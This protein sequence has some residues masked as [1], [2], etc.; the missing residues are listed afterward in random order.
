[1]N[2]IKAVR[3][4]ALAGLVPLLGASTAVAQ[5][6]TITGTITDQESG[7]PLSSAQVVVVGT[8]IGTITNVEGAYTLRGVPAGT[9]S[10]RALSIGYS[11]QTRQVT[12]E[13]G[14]IATADFALRATAISM[15][16]MVVTATG[17]QRRIEVGNSIA[18][19]DASRITQQRAVSNF[20]DLM[21]SRTA[22]VQ[23]IPGT[24]TGAG[25]RFRIRGTS[26]LSLAN[27]PIF[28]IDGVRVE[29]TTGS[30]SVGVGGTT[31]ARINDINPEEI[32]S[33]EIVRGPS[34]ATLY[35]TDAANGVVVIQTKRGVAGRAQ[36]SYYTE[37]TAIVDNNDYPD[38]YWG[39][40]AASTRS[41]TTQCYLFQ[42]AAGSCAQDSVTV[43]NPTADDES[44]PFGTG[45]RQQH[46]L[47]LRG[48]TEAIR[49]F[50]HGEW[51]DETG[52]LKVPEFDQRW[53]AARN[54]TL[55]D[56]QE[57]PNAL[58]RVT[59]RSNLDVTLSDEFDFSVNA[60]YTSQNLRLP[61]SDDS[62]VPGVA[63]NIYGGPGYEYML[64][65]AGDTLHGWR[66][67]TPREI[68]R[69]TTEQNIRRFI[70]SVASNW[71]P[72][73]WLGLRANV[74]LD[75]INRQDTQ[76]CRF[77]E[78]PVSGDDHL[79]FKVDN[80]T[81]F[82]IYT[83]DAAAT[84]TRSFSD[85]L[86]G[87]TILGVQYYQ[88][89]FDRNGAEGHELPPGATTINAGAVQFADETS[90][91]S[92]TLGAFVEQQIAFRD[93]LFLTGAIR[94][95]RNSAFGA[96][97]KTV[98]YPKFSASWVVSEEEFF[99]TPGWLSQ[100]RLRTA[101]GASGV[102]PGTTAAVEFY[103]TAQML[104]EAGEASGL[105]YTSVGNRELKP[106]RSTELE[107]GVDGTFFDDRL[108][109]EITYYTKTSRDQLISRILAPSIGTGSTTRFENLGEVHNS[110]W[111]AVLFA[112]LVQSDAFGWDLQFSGSTMS[113]ELVSLGGEPN[114]IHSS[115]QQSRE[116][117]PLYGWWAVK[118]LGWEDRNGD[119]LISWFADPAL[120]EIQ[121]SDTAEYHGYSM[122]RR[123]FAVSTGIDL[124]RGK[125]RLTGMMDYKG[126]HLV[127]NN[128][129]R[130]RCASRNN[131]AGLI[132]PSSSH[133]E[134]AR[135]QLVRLHPSR[136]VG[137]FF[138]DG[139]F[140]RLRELGMTIIPPDSWVSAIRAR[141]ASISLAAR[142]LGIIWTEYTGVD[143]EAFG[144]TGNAPSSFQA[145]APP[146][147][148]T[149]RLNL[150]F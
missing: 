90:D 78:C 45:Y 145:F 93:R 12:V 35:G 7:Q 38:A 114:I 77:S 16:P 150:G 149:L 121:V 96:D 99:P 22:G 32:E 84:A 127:Y 135:T 100:L 46:G 47:Q 87:T 79:G 140:L 113:N 105:V 73:D 124:L 139:D 133:Y 19:V 8:N 119:G 60:G 2:R 138:E 74:G 52:S 68:Y 56:E 112:Q 98:F 69:T 39:W 59:A 64:N 34:A 137:G 144:T 4:L 148:F 13:S 86:K 67:V 33:I 95:D 63:T 3:R 30:M 50:V 76:L 72:T 91:E 27:D 118:L 125:L 31:P 111:E 18:N 142:N 14:G 141:S 136:S 132:N 37:Q 40:T 1:M 42:V 43:Y 6:G 10:V 123:E 53:L 92:R 66:T 15:D 51:E 26:S 88:S 115:S 117:Y 11:E 106:E 81:N 17:E 103:T 107:L 70:G 80:R 147:Y 134:Q 104:G 71:R 116:G 97:F 21:T 108:S 101:Y 49:Y 55:R 130:I 94:S 109:T 131:C 75:Y 5:Q 110:G 44:T 23:V 120:N 36:W 25:V 28:I 54:I 143:P 24:Q 146:T 89:I 65:A 128:S 48:G 122:P 41:N 102:Q 129:E 29:G 83:L 9:V 58:N 61:R 85:A 62:G 82:F 20:A 57:R 126:G